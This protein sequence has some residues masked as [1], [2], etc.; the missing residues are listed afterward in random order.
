MKLSHSLHVLFNHILSPD[1]R[2][3]AGE[4]GVVLIVLPEV[5]ER[6]HSE[7]FEVAV[8]ERGRRHARGVEGLVAVG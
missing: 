2:T 4:A 1:G 3:N 5:A 6:R 8:P 7:V